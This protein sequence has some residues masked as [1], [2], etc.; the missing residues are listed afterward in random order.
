MYFEPFGEGNAVNTGVPCPKV[1]MHRKLG[2]GLRPVVPLARQVS[3]NQTGQARPGVVSGGPRREAA[4][5]MPARLLALVRG[6][7]PT[8]HQ[9]HWVREVPCDADRSPGRGGPLPAVLAALRNTTIGLL[10]WAG[11]T[12]IAAACRQLAAPPA[13]AVALVGIAL[14]N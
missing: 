2:P 9:A 3:I 7:W 12:T 4:P 6:Q 13:R 5:A 1:P 10:R 8:G 14:E 11:D